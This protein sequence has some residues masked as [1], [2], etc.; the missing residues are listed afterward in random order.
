MDGNIEKYIE[1]YIA[2]LTPF[3]LCSRRTEI[4][5]ETYNPPFCLTFCEIRFI[6]RRIAIKFLI[7][8]KTAL[9]NC[10]IFKD[11]LFC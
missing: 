3:V 11:F 7:L 4:H 2:C 5:N 9:F 1:K 10:L 8:A 6:F